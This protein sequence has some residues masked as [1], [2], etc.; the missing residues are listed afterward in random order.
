MAIKYFKFKTKVSVNNVTMDKYVARMQVETKIDFDKMAE[1]IE[2]RST[3]SKGDIMAVLSELESSSAWMLEEGH[4][5]ELGIFG[6]FYP[7][8]EAMAMDTPEEVT[9]DTIVKFKTIF[10]PSKF[11]K[12]RFKEV[13][14]LLGDNKVREVNYSKNI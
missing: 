6:T 1:I 10:K 11:L 9:N 8:L 3:V 14:F 2:K 12:K 7:T 5:I 4:P 13:N